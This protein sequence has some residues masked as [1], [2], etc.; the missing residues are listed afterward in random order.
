MAG[1]LWSG[2]SGYDALS[3]P[4][5]KSLNEFAAIV[6]R[7]FKMYVTGKYSDGEIAAWMNTKKP[8]QQLRAGRK[9]MDKEVVRDMLQNRTYTGRVSHSDTQY[10]GSLGEGKK[11]S[12]HR[13]VWYEGRHQGF[14]PD[15]LYDQCQEVREHVGGRHASPSRIRTY[16]LADRVYCA[17]PNQQ[18]LR[19]GG[20]ALWQNARFGG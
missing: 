9:P 2:F 13:K 7:A 18:A 10:T 16:V 20:R 17:V 3:F 8:I 14:I 12:R 15:A 4:F 6:R 5:F 1:Y 19:P 11:S